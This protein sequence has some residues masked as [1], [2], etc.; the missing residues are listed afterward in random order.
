MPRD[1]KRGFRP[2]TV[3]DEKYFWRVTWVEQHTCLEIQYAGMRNG[4]VLFVELRAKPMMGLIGGVFNLDESGQNIVVRPKFVREA[5]LYGL[6][7]GWTPHITAPTLKIDAHEANLPFAELVK[8]EFDLVLDDIL[9]QTPLIDDTNLQGFNTDL[10]HALIQGEYFTNLNTQRTDD[11]RCILIATGESSP[12]CQDHFQV[13]EFLKKQWLSN[14]CYK[15]FEA[16][17]IIY[18]PE[19]IDFRFVTINKIANY[20]V[21]GKIAIER[22]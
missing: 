2:M 20:C 17:R 5:V 13:S 11:P 4:Q 1:R 15:G 22:Y 6:E 12:A 7:H 9:S 14:I 19:T 3:N 10:R 16:H 18:K 8:T 21:T